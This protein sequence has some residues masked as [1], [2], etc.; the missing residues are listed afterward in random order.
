MNCLNCNAPMAAIDYCPSCGADMSILKRIERISNLSYNE[1]LDKAVVRDLSGAIVCL[2][3]S[4]KFNKRNIQ[5]RNLLGLVYF[6]TGEVVAA[7]S[8]WVISKNLQEKDNVADDYI[9]KLQSNPNKLNT[10]NQTVRKYNQALLYCQENSDD[11]A[12][13]QLKKLLSQ[14]PKLIKGQQLLALLYIRNK[15]Y[16]KARKIL[17]KAARIDTTNTIT[18]RYIKVVDEATGTATSLEGK[19]LRRREN[20]MQETHL[21]SVVYK[22]GNETIIQPATFQESSI[23]ATFINITLGL[24]V[25]A[26]VVWFLVIP[27]KTQKFEEKSNKQVVEFSNQISVQKGTIAELEKEKEGF[28]QL[29]EAA[30][31]KEEQANAKADSYEA[32]LKVAN[33]NYVEEDKE[34]VADMIEEIAVDTLSEDGQALLQAIQKDVNGILYQ[35]YYDAGSKAYLTEKN[36]DAAIENLLKALKVNPDDYQ[37]LYYLAFA[38]R[39][40]KDYVNSNERFNELITKFPDKN[41]EENFRQYLM[42]DTS[43]SEEGTGD[44]EQADEE[45]NQDQEGNQGEQDNQN[46]EVN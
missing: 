18:L 25:G 2:K 36:N 9:K 39:D 33:A 3:R 14:N 41:N 28:S 6:E 30:A 5:A 20:K 32:L 27:A 22:D 35:R 43:V 15:D 10:I 31:E 40:K 26:A 11:V 13:I 38:Y 8:E 23:V 44:Q 16:E 45:G 1:G 46:E 21:G 37:S 24:I 34:K 4:L 42:E 29:Q 12:I 17:K 19:R 7:L